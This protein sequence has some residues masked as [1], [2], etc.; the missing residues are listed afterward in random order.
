MYCSGFFFQLRA[1]DLLHKAAFRRGLGNSLYSAKYNLGA[2]STETLQHYVAS[3]FL[4]G[5]TAVVGLGV[6]HS[7]LVE[8]AQ[9]LKLES[10][11]GTVTPSPYAGGE[12]RS[13]KS[14][15]LAFVA[16]AG[17]GAALKNGREALAFAVLQRALGVG[18]QIKWAVNDNGI[19]GKAINTTEVAVSAINVSYSDAGLLGALIAGPGDTIGKS[20]EAVIK[21]LKGGSVTD[22]DVTRGKNQLKAA[23]LL[24]NE[25]GTNAIENIGLQAALLG[26]ARP[27]KDVIPEIDSVSTAD[28]KA[29]SFFLLQNFFV[30]K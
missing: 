8:Y 1:V 11:E 6:D 25:S 17:N 19:L 16:I 20:V 26:V 24:D 30:C 28:V 4:T 3:N 9:G 29:V 5:R 7:K 23:L 15:N 13:D 27:I 10:G 22:A 12:I 21:V 18:P 14:G 2:I